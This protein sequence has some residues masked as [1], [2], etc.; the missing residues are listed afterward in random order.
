MKRLKQ[1]CKDVTENPITNQVWN[2]LYVP[3]DTFEEYVDQ[4]KSFRD[5]AKICK[6]YQ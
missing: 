3:Q 5:L 2:F 6:E 4:L 1:Y